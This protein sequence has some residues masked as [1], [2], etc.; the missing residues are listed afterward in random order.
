MGNG[1]KLAGNYC[2]E[3]KCEQLIFSFSLLFRLENVIMKTVD[4][5]SFKEEM[6]KTSDSLEND[7]KQF[8]DLEFQYLEEETD[9]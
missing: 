9:W 6:D 8:E 2:V 5:T 3:K 1:I 4:N 7:I